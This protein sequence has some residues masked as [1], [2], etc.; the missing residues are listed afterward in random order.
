MPVTV[1]TIDAPV[2][3]VLTVKV[4]EVFPAGMETDAGTVAAELLLL[5]LTTIPPFEAGPLKV[6]VPVDE[7]PPVSESGLRLIESNPGGITVSVAASCTPLYVAVII[8][9]C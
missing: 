3:L 7:A 9:T 1:A 8:A 5:S 2:T 6:A 4:A